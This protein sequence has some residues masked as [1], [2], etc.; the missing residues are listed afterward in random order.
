[1]KLALKFTLN[2]VRL[3]DTFLFFLNDRFNSFL[4]E[5]IRNKLLHTKSNLI[6]IH[7]IWNGDNF[8]NS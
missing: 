6:Q 8:L 3:K 1:M 2:Y 4:C 5:S 7:S